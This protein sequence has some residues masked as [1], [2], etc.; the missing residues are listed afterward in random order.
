MYIVKKINLILEE[1]KSILK[2]NKKEYKQINLIIENHKQ[3]K[4]I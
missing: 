3:P 4:H 2:R 1:Y